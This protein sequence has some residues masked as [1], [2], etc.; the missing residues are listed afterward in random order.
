MKEIPG[1]PRLPLARSLGIFMWVMVFSDH[2]CNTRYISIVKKCFSS[3]LRKENYLRIA[4]VSAS[5]ELAQGQITSGLKPLDWN[6]F[7][8]A[9]HEDIDP[10]KTNHTIGNIL[11]RAGKLEL[12]DFKVYAYFQL[13]YTNMVASVHKT[14]IL[15]KLSKRHSSLLLDVRFGEKTPS[16]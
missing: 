7:R 11:P 6:T 14:N 9:S 4:T 16:G 12:Q 10:K 15:T 1:S 5:E 8:N 2:H 3:L 13:S